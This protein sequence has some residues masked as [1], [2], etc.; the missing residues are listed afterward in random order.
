MTPKSGAGPT[1]RTPDTL[2]ELHR[3]KSNLVVHPFR[4]PWKEPGASWGGGYRSENR[5]QVTRL[6]NERPGR[7]LC[8]ENKKIT[9]Q[10]S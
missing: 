9:D 4:N 5:G 10:T 3:A 2:T 7:Q 6:G 1:A 8:D